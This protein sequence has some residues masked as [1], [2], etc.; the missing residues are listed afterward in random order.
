MSSFDQR[1][2]R[3]RRFPQPPPPGPMFK[4]KTG[5][6]LGTS[7]GKDSNVLLKFK[8]VNSSVGAN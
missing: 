8:H 2:P 1:T 5:M 7:L 3:N 6:N 4:G